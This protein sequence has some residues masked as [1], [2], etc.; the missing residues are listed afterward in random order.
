MAA[1]FRDLLIPIAQ[2]LAAN[3]SITNPDKTVST[4]RV[5]GSTDPTYGSIGWIP[6]LDDS[7]FALIW[8]DQTH[9]DQSKQPQ[10]V[11]ASYRLHLFLGVTHV[12]TPAT[13]FDYNDE[14]L[15]WSESARQL[16]AQHIYLM[17]QSLALFPTAGDVTWVMTDAEVVNDHAILGAHWYGAHI[18]TTVRVVT[19][20]Q[21]Q[22]FN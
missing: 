6:P 10:R 2:I 14:V 21:Y 8:W 13:L 12:D 7:P 17:P 11:W 5:A 16:I 20:V 15:A 9:D 4:V 3:W 18:I 22:F 1:G 19:T